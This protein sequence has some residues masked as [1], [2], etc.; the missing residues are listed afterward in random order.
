M[1]KKL[2]VQESRGGP[3]DVDRA[4]IGTV[5]YMLWHIRSVH[6]YSAS[7]IALQANLQVV[8]A[9]EYDFGEFC[10]HNAFG[11]RM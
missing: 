8:R 7:K 10:V 5:R 2:K 9:L 4:A 11:D 6:H 1:D 3:L